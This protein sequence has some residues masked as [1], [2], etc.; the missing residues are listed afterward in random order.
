MCGTKKGK[1]SDR[2]RTAVRVLSQ[3]ELFVV[4]ASGKVVLHRKIVLQSLKSRYH[5]LQGERGV[6][7]GRRRR[8]E[9]RLQP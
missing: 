2:R 7:S 8:A 1:V 5:G 4:R 9:C 3:L 6:V